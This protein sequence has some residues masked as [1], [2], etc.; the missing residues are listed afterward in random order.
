MSPATGRSRTLRERTRLSESARVSGSIIRGV[1]VLAPH[2]RNGRRYSRRA[3]EDVAERAEGA[4]VFLDHDEGSRRGG[5]PRTV[6]DLVG[7][8]RSARVVRGAVRADLRLLDSEHRP[9]LLDLAED[10]PALVGL[11]IAARGKVRRGDDGED[12]VERVTDLA[13]VDVVTA[14]ATTTSLFEQ[15]GELSA[16]DLRKLAARELARVEE[17]GPEETLDVVALFSDR[18]VYRIGFDGPLFERSIEEVDAENNVVR[19]G[20]DRR[21]V[22]ERRVFEPVGRDEDEED[23]ETEESRRRTPRDPTDEDLSEAYDRLWYAP[24]GP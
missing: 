2:S 15:E 5:E 19:L 21:E 14:P 10:A 11:S 23:A 7:V 24:Y 22:V 16:E 20:E 13:S 8:I 1:A 4:R 9:F 17:V 6:R 18:V 12:V 3:L